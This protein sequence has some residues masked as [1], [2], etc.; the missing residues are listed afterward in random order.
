MQSPRH[1]AGSAVHARS[2][3][4]EGF[5]TSVCHRARS[6]LSNWLAVPACLP[7]SQSF[8]SS[9]ESCFLQCSGL[10]DI[11][12]Q[13]ISVCL[14][15]HKCLQSRVNHHPLIVISFRQDLSECCLQFLGRE[16]QPFIKHC[17][18]LW[19]GQQHS[20]AGLQIGHGLAALC[21]SA[22]LTHR[23]A[24]SIAWAFVSNGPLGAF[25]DASTQYQPSDRLSAFPKNTPTFDGRLP[26]LSPFH[27]AASNPP[28]R[29]RDRV[30]IW[31]I[32]LT[33]LLSGNFVDGAGQ[34]TGGE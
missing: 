34:V 33:S 6:L 21:S 1:H 29:R 17:F 10:S 2:Q 26:I 15:R 14:P 8:D 12:I 31:I 24:F 20:Q 28:I 9:F 5:V 4:G 18:P 32:G 27:L 16:L 22:V 23:T 3:H 30:N 13:S 25:V 7:T 19:G 11:R